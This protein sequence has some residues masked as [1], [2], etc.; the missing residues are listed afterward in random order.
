MIP[1]KYHYIIYNYIFIVHL[2]NVINLCNISINLVKLYIVKFKINKLHLHWM[3]TQCTGN[4]TEIYAGGSHTH[5]PHLLDAA[6]G[7]D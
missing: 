2:F 3:A 5:T 1:N 4:L 6:C 7:S